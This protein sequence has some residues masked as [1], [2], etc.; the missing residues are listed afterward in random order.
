MVDPLD[1]TMFTICAHERSIQ[2]FFITTQLSTL[3]EQTYI[4]FMKFMLA[5]WATGEESV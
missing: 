2:H 5:D 1:S 3:L 4:S